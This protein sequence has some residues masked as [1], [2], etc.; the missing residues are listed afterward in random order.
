MEVATRET[1]HLIDRLV[2][3]TLGPLRK[4]GIDIDAASRRS[5]RLAC[6]LSSRSVLCK[7]GHDCV[8]THSC[9]ERAQEAKCELQVEY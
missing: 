2:S 8:S 5:L 4:E 6:P 7:I 1:A 3:N 9:E